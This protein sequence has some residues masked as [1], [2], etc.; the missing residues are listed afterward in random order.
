MK[1]FAV[2]LLFFSFL[3]VSQAKGYIDSGSVY[4]RY[5]G[6]ACIPSSN[7]VVGIHI[8]ASGV[9]IGGGNAGLTREF[10]VR[11]ACGS[12][13]SNHGFDI[14]AKYGTAHFNSLSL[15]NVKVVSHPCH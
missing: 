5:V 4:N 15:L 2:F 1:R 14:S 12:A 6:W 10:A 11:D 9:Y 13:D 7:E 8:Y 3:S